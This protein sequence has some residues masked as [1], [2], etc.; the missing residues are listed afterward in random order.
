MACGHLVIDFGVSLLPC[1]LLRFISQTHTC[2]GWQVRH[3]HSIQNVAVGLKFYA[4]RGE[5][6]WGP[7][8]IDVAGT[9]SSAQRH[10]AAC[11]SFTLTCTHS[12]REHKALLLEQ[13]DLVHFALFDQLNT[14]VA[15]EHFH[16][17][18]AGLPGI[19]NTHTYTHKHDHIYIWTYM[20]IYE[21]SCSSC[22]L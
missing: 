18:S 11:C 4:R 1:Y 16:L 9:Y 20:G 14:T 3:R 12:L 6:V 19:S 17:L 8:V 5:Y 7:T 21:S 22:Y 10:R 13:Q 2:S 15:G